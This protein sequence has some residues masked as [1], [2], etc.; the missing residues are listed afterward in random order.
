MNRVV[1]FLRS[2]GF[3][4]A[5][6]GVPAPTAPAG[7]RSHSE[8]SQTDTSLRVERATADDALAAKLA[9]IDETADAVIS[10]ARARADVLL[11]AARAKTDRQSATS[12]VAAIIERERMRE[13]T[14]LR[15]ERATADATLRE[16]RAEH[17]TL[18]SIERD[19]TDKDLFRERARS[20]ASLATRDEF[21]GIVSHDLRGMLHVVV[22]FAGLIEAGVCREDHVEQVLM[23]ARRILRSGARMDRLIG[24]LVDVASIEAG[25]LGV[26]REIGDPTEV[27]K[28]VVDSFQARAAA[29][30]VSLAAEIVSPLPL[31]VFDPA[32]ILQVITN[33]LS[34]AIKFTPAKGH[35][36]VR[37][38]R[39]GDETRVAVRDTGVGIASDHLE[40]V[41]DRFLQVT[42][43]D[44]RGVGLGLYISKCIVQ[45]HGGRM[46]AE[47]RVGHGSTFFFTLPIPETAA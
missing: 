26:T 28:E 19:E 34:N 27:V 39:I 17:V 7:E 40:A 9:A 32:R 42:R 29:C 44:R 10:R 15:Q 1:T 6:R 43:N 13:D 41:F 21:M 4:R 38:E 25:M 35:V 3:D 45:S 5:A 30:G 37:V 18:L 31:A 22:G 14:L 8:R 33:L 16:E 2:V 24:D 12:S 47:S 36:V 46:W 23:D 11:A 20:D